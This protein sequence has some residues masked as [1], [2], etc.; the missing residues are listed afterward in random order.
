M[1]QVIVLEAF[2][3]WYRDFDDVDA[4]QVTV[5]VDLLEARGTS[6]RYPH[7]SA[8]KNSKAALRELRIQSKGRRL[9][10]F[11]RF[12][13]KR[14]AVLILGGDKTGNDSFFLEFIRQAEKLWDD[15]LNEIQEEG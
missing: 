12:D 2:E 11:Y 8:I 15:Y 10:V 1:V 14:Q 7:S 3:V 13:P 6:L 5:V 9:R 4:E